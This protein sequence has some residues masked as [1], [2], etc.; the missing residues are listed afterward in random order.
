MARL[1]SCRLEGVLMTGV[2][3]GRFR[4]PTEKWSRCFHSIISLPVGWARRASSVDCAVFTLDYFTA[5]G[6]DAQTV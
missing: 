5:G 6:V 1:Q 2:G 3:T 4:L